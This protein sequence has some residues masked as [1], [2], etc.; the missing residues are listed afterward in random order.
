MN[1]AEFERHAWHYSNPEA[2]TCLHCSCSTSDPAQTSGQ[3]LVPLDPNEVVR[4]VLKFAA[5]IM[6]KQ[7]QI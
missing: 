6:D 2:T 4:D 1:N 3:T 7:R 5:E